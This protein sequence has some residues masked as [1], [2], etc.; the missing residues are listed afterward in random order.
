MKILGVRFLNL[1][2]LKGLHEI[3]F[4]QSPIADAGLFAITGSTGA[5]KTTLLD[6]ITVALYGRVH[7]HD[8]DA[9][10]I[11]TR[12]TGECFSE[13]EFEVK[14]QQYCAKWSLYRSRKKHDGNLQ[15]TYMA[16][17][18]LPDQK[19][20]DL[21]PSEVPGKVAEI[22]G[23]DYSQFLRSVML[24]QGDFTRFLKA[25]ESERSELLE[26][27][28]DTDIYSRISVWAYRKADAEKKAL[29]ALRARLDYSELLTDEQVSIYQ[30]QLTALENQV[31]EQQQT[32]QQQENK[33]NWLA[34]L[35]KLQQK[36]TELTAELQILE[37]DYEAQQIEFA[38][39]QRH[40]QALRFKPAL[41]QIKSSENQAQRLHHDLLD[42]NNRLPG[43]HQQTSEAEHLMTQAR[44]EVTRAQKELDDAEPILHEVTRQDFVIKSNQDYFK[45]GR[46]Q[47]IRSEAELKKTGQLLQEK[48]AAL[49]QLQV[50]ILQTENWLQANQAAQF[51][52]RE[53]ISFQEYIKDLRD[54]DR[55]T[56]AFTQEQTS[57]KVMLDNA[58]RL[59]QER[60]Q[61]LETLGKN[62]EIYQQQALDLQA[63]LRNLLNGQTTAQAEE[64]C[65][66]LPTQI[67]NLEQLAG[68]ARQHQQLSQKAAALAHN[69]QQSE[70]EQLQTR[71]QITELT[72]KLQQATEKLN[73][74]QQIVD[75]ERLIQKYEDDRSL[76]QPDQPC[77]LCGSAHHPFVQNHY[78]SQ[79]SVAE[80]KRAA[81]QNIVSEVTN[82]YNATVTRLNTI[83]ALR[84]NEQSQAEQV[85]TEQ[86]NL[87]AQFTQ[88]LE[89]IPVT[90]TIDQVQ[91]I[92]ER[93]VTLQQQYQQQR[94]LL[95]QIRLT[96]QQL[97]A[98]EKTAQ[99]QK[100]NIL[101]LN[102]EIAQAQEKEQQASQQYLKIQDE[103]SDLT[104][105]QK[106][107]TG[108]VQS[109]LV[110]FNIPFRLEN[111][112]KIEA[113]LQQRAHTYAQKN[114]DLQQLH[115]QLKQTE[116]EAR[117]TQESLSEKE[118]TLQQ[119]KTQL[120]QQHETLQQLTAARKNLFGVKDPQ[121]ARE[122]LKLA[123]NH[124]LAR[125]EQMRIAFQEKQEQMRLAQSR[126]EQW[127]TDL[128]KVQAEVST[129]TAELQTSVRAHNIDSVDTLVQLFLTDDEATRIESL[130]KQAERALTES[131][132]LYAD[133]DQELTREL[134]LALT[135]TDA[136]TLHNEIKQLEE[137]IARLHQQM[138]SLQLQLRQDAEL[139]AKYREIAAQIE[140]QQ[141]EFH[142]W[143]KMAALIGSAD[144]KKFSKF[145]QGLTLARLTELANR[146]LSKLN[147]RYRI[148]KSPTHD[149][150]LQIID[151][152]QADAVR[153]MNTLSGGESFL[154]SLA[155]AL[156]LSDLA[157]RKA[158]I[159]SLFIDEGFGTLDADT[160]DIAITALENLQAGGKFIGIISHVEALKERIGTQIQV[161]KQAGGQSTIKVIGY[162]T[163]TFV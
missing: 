52:D 88:Q 149:L 72:D 139:K 95:A 128:A 43:Y 18:S 19:I 102:H 44:E 146:H 75:L 145:A 22:S 152:H 9:Y 89:N 143:D 34:R 158:Q 39:L 119:Q 111:S 10:E 133:T 162:A 78:Q 48:Q 70:A 37:A 108:Q 74:L 100:E 46:E 24:S 62:Q 61:Q 144:G 115:L 92:Q 79:V 54:I 14:G 45:Q 125:L 69:R 5:G 91:A 116:T 153:S 163:E 28:T 122:Q 66:Q 68:L 132:K 93:S 90:V 15:P 17:V 53:I 151:T 12:H 159:N 33:V 82:Q 155:L 27:I 21:K 49:A 65:N 157:G 135:I 107:V 87:L 154:V 6:A 73:H 123:L 141:R 16:L 160:L 140:I 147:D 55:K 51:L 13:V 104:E 96:E 8:R 121:A 120:Q 23:L 114:L 38:R 71:Q 30:E 126:Q 58:Q 76:L 50:Q 117:N 64:N 36:K 35:A 156:G 101:R 130:Q 7:R 118:Y 32:R 137:A 129:L 67:S 83:L 4:D 63:T 85:K 97:A 20:L 41:I 150:E 142:R 112:Q 138:G 29:E 98:L 1:N 134:N 113:D 26:K 31:R 161:Q 80:Q 86:A 57:L 94:Q 59:M 25:S 11:M 110:R 105:Q 77:P 131:R 109:F 3:R 99:Q 124:R 56:T 2:S 103:L 84:A 136:V 60:V 106:V 148:Y 42:I 40:Q 127:Q 47:Y 81:Q